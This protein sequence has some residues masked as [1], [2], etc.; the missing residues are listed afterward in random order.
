MEKNERNPDWKPQK[1]RIKE[2]TDQLEAGI[3]ELFESNKFKEYLKCMSKFHHY[4]LNNTLLIASQKPDATLVASYTSWREDHDRSVRKGEK[5][6]KIIAPTKYKVEVKDEETGETTTVQRLGFKVAYVFDVSQTEGEALPAIA[7]PEL[8]GSPEN[9]NKLWKALNK[10]CPVPICFE[11]TGNAKGYY[12]D[13][14]KYIA[15]KNDIS[16]LQAVK[17]LIHEMAHQMLHSKENQDPDHPVDRNAMEVEAE[18]V[19]YTVCQ[20]YGLD[21]SEYS[22]GYIAGWSSG[23]EVTELRN[24][25]ERIRQT[26]DT[27]ITDLDKELDPRSRTAHH[28][29]DHDNER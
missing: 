14:E 1:E 12:N 27:L 22:F 2:I 19:A 28:R 3:K 7:V 16:E 6:I 5:G 17:T 25:L 20:K 13:A 26:A 11:D 18:S 9:C 8:T 15:I 24:S 29:A 21:T 10:I 4:S 23:K